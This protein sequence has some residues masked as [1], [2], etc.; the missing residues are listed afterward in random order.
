MHNLDVSLQVMF[1]SELHYT[2]QAFEVLFVCMRDHMSLEVGA[3]FEL[4]A[5]ELTRILS[6]LAFLM[7]LTEMAEQMGLL[8]EP[9][10]AEG[11]GDSESNG[12]ERRSWEQAWGFELVW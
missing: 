10:A 2:L 8:V 5:T 9:L 1:I 3:P 11:A 6:I 7:F 12:V 4:L